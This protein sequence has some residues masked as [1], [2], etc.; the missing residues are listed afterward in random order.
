MIIFKNK[1]KLKSLL[2]ISFSWK[3][4][5]SF[6]KTSKHLQEI[7]VSPWILLFHSIE[8]L[9]SDNKAFIASSKTF[10]PKYR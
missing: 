7:L 9:F 2:K 5:E 1:T 10:Q 3:F 4:D 8:Y 6:M